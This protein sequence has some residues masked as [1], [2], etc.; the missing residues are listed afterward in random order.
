MYCSNNRET[1]IEYSSFGTNYWT[2]FYR[3]FNC[4]MEIIDL[5]SACAV[6]K[7][8]T[9]SKKKVKFWN[10]KYSNRSLKSEFGLADKVR[11]K[12]SSYCFY[13]L[14]NLGGKENVCS[15]HVKTEWKNADIFAMLGVVHRYVKYRNSF[16]W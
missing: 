1:A 4:W 9:K 16:P 7:F 11:P 6:I 15:V 2:L 12:N 10:S 14:T 3:L 13:S 8:L 5:F